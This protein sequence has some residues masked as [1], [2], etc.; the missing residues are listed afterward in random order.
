MAEQWSSGA[1]CSGVLHCGALC[2]A[3]LA[4]R[5]CIVC[6]AIII[7]GLRVFL[8]PPVPVCKRT[9]GFL[10]LTGRISRESELVQNT[11]SSPP[12]TA[13]PLARHPYSKSLFECSDTGRGKGM[14]TRRIASKIRNP[15][16]LRTTFIFRTV[17]G[18]CNTAQV[19]RQ[20][21]AVTSC[22][23]YFHA[24]TYTLNFI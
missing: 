20:F 12:T 11:I 1:P 18:G 7:A 10:C 23:V 15:G 8:E 13:L 2:R 21:L 17:H 3:V 5:S 9:L 4:L 14:T 22:H 24:S 6:K 16:P 19:R